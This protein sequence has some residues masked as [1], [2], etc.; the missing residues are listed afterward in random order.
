MTRAADRLRHWAGALEGTAAV[1]AGLV[2][3]GLTAYGFLVVTARALGPEAYAPLSAL[4]AIVFLLGPGCFVPIEQ[5]LAR[6]L[7]AR[8]AAGLGGGP[9]IRQAAALGGT[10]LVVLTALCAVAGFVLL[11]QLFDGQSL[12]VVGLLLSLAGYFAEHLVRGVLAGHGRFRPYGVAL[13]AEGTVRLIGCAVLAGLGV[14]TAGP[15]GIVLG[16]APLLAAAV[17]LR[18]NRGL[19]PPGPDADRRE[20]TVALG[21]LLAGS[22]LAQVMANA[23]PVAVKLLA[24]DDERAEAGRFLAAL[25]VA[26]V[27]MFL[28]QAVLAPALPRLARMAAAGDRPGFDSG[29]RRLLVVV[30]GLGAAGTLGALVAGPLVVRTL[31]GP[32]FELPTRDLAVLALG[33]AAYLLALTLGQALIA[34]S[35]QGRVALAW[36]AGVVAFGTVTALGSDLLTRVELGLLAGSIVAAAAMAGLLLPV[37]AHRVGPA[38]A[39]AADLVASP[40]PGL[41]P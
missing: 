27:P 38:P 14:A 9:V 29:L 41:A 19:A 26:R 13:A 34:V 33:C 25:I 37:L 4:W 18:G 17:A 5:E 10:A 24:A 30:V 23:G 8:R 21:W 16:A 1:A 39:A 20:V 31:F 36:L 22:V 7:A 35:G 40:P 15:Y 2:V 28:F 12:L 6:S 11:D 32:D 3:L